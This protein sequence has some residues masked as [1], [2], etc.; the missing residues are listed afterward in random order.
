MLSLC[1]TCYL[2]VT[3]SS[4][5]FSVAVLFAELLNG[6]AG[7]QYEGCTTAKD[8]SSFMFKQWMKMK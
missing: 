6:D 4:D 8:R 5:V 2:Q 3:H 1:W 7:L